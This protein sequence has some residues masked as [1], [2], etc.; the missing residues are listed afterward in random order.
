MLYKFGK[1]EEAIR[2]NEEGMK[3]N[4]ES[5]NLELNAAQFELAR[6]NDLKSA[7][8]HF[9]RALLRT[10]E[11]D[12]KLFALQYLHTIYRKLNMNDKALEVEVQI[13]SFKNIQEQEDIK[14][15]HRQDH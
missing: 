10:L 11:A 13:A 15:E 3:M 12:E 7:A 8:R 2:F 9:E 5:G 1:L 14:S 4:P 6:H